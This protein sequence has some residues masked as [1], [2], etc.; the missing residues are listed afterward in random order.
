MQSQSR[1]SCPSS[2]T[3]EVS[4]TQL[5]TVVYSRVNISLINTQPNQDTAKFTHINRSGDERFERY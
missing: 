1:V 5:L 2:L 3:G 4:N